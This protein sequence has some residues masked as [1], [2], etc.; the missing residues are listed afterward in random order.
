MVRT[1]RTD[2]QGR[3]TFSSPPGM[4]HVSPFK[5]PPTLIRVPGPPWKEITVSE[6]QARLELEPWEA[7]PAAPPLRFIVRDETAG[8][9]RTRRITGQSA[10]HYMPETTDDDGEFAVPGLPPGSEVSIEVRLGR[11]DDGRAGQG[12]RGD[13]AT[14][15]GHDRPG[16]R[17]RPGGPRGRTGRHAD[18]RWPRCASSSATRRRRAGIRL[19]PDAQF[20]AT[21]PRSGPGPTGRSGRR[22][23]STGRIASSASRSPPWAS[24]DG[25]T[26]WASANG[27]ERITFPDLVLRRV[28]R[29]GLI[30]G[31][32][33]DRGGKGVAAVTVFRPSDS[34][35]GR[36]RSPMSEG[37]FRL[38]GVPGGPALVFAEKAGYRFG[39]AVVGPGDAPVEIRLARAEEPPLS[40]PQAGPAAAVPG[41]G[42]VHRARVIAPCWS[43]PPGRVR[44][45]R[46]VKPSFP[47]WRGLIPIASWRCWRTGC[48][49]RR[50]TC[51]TRS[52]WRSSRTTRQRRWPTIEADR[53]PA[54]RAEGFLALADA[55]TDDQAP[56]PDRAGS[57]ARWPRPVAS[58]TRSSR[59]RL[60]RQVADRWLELGLVDRGDADPSPGAG[61]HRIAAAGPSTPSPPRTS[62]RC[63]P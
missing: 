4:W 20:R 11:T 27:G 6:G 29:R 53:D 47:P 61:D 58:R 54:A 1:A 14:G 55:M 51:S 41:R 62:P 42:A 36:R 25:K 19:P 50:R 15:C 59:L 17:D 30:A 18:R 46:W 24:S 23:R 21:G 26:D 33:V 22:R 3:Y 7:I 31:R 39:G 63:W 43:S 49:R 28:R 45:A 5:L 56:A 9:R 52:R 16:A 10:S 40:I 48:C 44:S 60:L 8:R 2:A 13:G 32:V 12:H 38:D 57:T 34:P 35:G 37:R